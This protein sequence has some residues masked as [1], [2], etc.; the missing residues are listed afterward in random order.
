IGVV[1][2]VPAIAACALTVIAVSS[3]ISM[4][5]PVLS[6]HLAGLGI[7]PA[8][9]GMVYGVA[10]LGGTLLHP[11]YGR[12]ADRFGARRS[13]LIRL[14]VLAAAKSRGS[15]VPEKEIT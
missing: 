12:P 7:D 4:L 3:T 10:A 6:L 11:I 15:A 1:L 13:T 2:R 8:R 14:A 5:E 9:V